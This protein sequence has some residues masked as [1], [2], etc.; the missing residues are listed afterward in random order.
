MSY[1]VLARKWRPQTFDEVIGQ[2]HIVRSLI[3]QI[4]SK[5]LGHA[6]LFSGTRGVGK[7]S[8]ARI[9]AKSL[10]CQS[11]DGSSEYNPCNVCS[12]CI[13]T[14]S[15]TSM[16]VIE[17][18]GASNNSVD[19]IR[20]IIESSKFLPTIGEKRIFII[21]EVHM[22]SSSAFNALLKTLEEPPEHVVFIFA[23]TEPEKLPATV[24]SRCQKYDFL[25]IST[26]NLVE[27]I[28]K[29][30]KAEGICFE[31]DHVIRK[32]C[33]HG[34][35]SVRDTLTLLE[36]ALMYSQDKK[37]N[38]ELIEKSLGIIQEDT[39]NQV[40]EHLILGQ[41]EELKEVFS[42]V[43]K[44]RI[45][46]DHFVL[47]FGKMIHRLILDNS[48]QGQKL[49][50]IELFN[51][52][53]MITN[54]EL[55]WVFDIFTRE[56]SD[57]LDGVFATIAVEVL[58]LK[59]CL[60]EEILKNINIKPKGKTETAPKESEV[61]TRVNKAEDKVDN[62]NKMVGPEIT[63]ESGATITVIEREEGKQQLSEIDSQVTEK[64]SSSE[65][66]KKVEVNKEMTW[67]GFLSNL[68]SISPA[69]ASN[70]EQ[71]NIINRIKYEEAD[72]LEIILGFST[73]S[74]VFF[75]YLSEKSSQE[76]VT[77][78]L[79]NYFE[80]ERNK[81]IFE[82]KLLE[83]SEKERIGFNSIVE[84]DEKIKEEEKNKKEQVL[85]NNN[86]IQEAQKLFKTEVDKTI[87]Q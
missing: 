32:I 78:E 66:E 22:L 79:A 7:T 84:I 72:K 18:D 21:D 52:K 53:A 83:D 85:L 29:I 76:K 61:L 75:D 19:N 42:K 48:M 27:Q 10:R 31:S 23:T 71:G 56:G 40:F 70:L 1:Q 39:L 2:D 16:D 47:E 63:N 45:K 64:D 8:M 9:L 87:I 68:S 35:G 69:T 57:A 25:E 82:L 41:S 28:K 43:K 11:L 51:S 4:S 30:S 49:F 34:D 14:T 81:I 13:D 55:M 77:D 33:Q 5:T 17:I 74:E 50:E 46:I 15:D 60:R 44:S 12:S 86:L 80:V 24:L 6:F 59:L 36:Q 37:I 3:N 54:A 73:E 58:L 62:E 67:E 26:D 38:A 65:G 20:E